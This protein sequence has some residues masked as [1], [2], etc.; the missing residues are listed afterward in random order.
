MKSDFQGEQ[1][2]AMDASNRNLEGT[3][4]IHGRLEVNPSKFNQNLG[5]QSDYGEVGF[6]TPTTPP[7]IKVSKIVQQ[8]EDNGRKTQT[9]I[10]GQGINGIPVE[11]DIQ[12]NHG[13]VTYYIK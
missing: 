3:A 12:S 6:A 5:V 8:N 2:G 4:G 7:N 13:G 1:A 10:G 9:N 11:G